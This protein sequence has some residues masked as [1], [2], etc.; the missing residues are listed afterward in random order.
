MDPDA[1][2]RARPMEIAYVWGM[3]RKILGAGHGPLDQKGGKLTAQ[4][5]PSP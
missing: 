1:V 4:D 2:A 3:R 5:Q